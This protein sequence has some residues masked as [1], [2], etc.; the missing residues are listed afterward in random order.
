MDREIA[1]ILHRR[2]RNWAYSGQD[3]KCL[4]ALIKAELTSSAEQNHIRVVILFV[5]MKDAV[6]PILRSTGRLK[7]TVPT[8]GCRYFPI[9]C[10]S[11]EEE[12]IRLVE[13]MRLN[14][15]SEENLDR[16]NAYAEY[17]LDLDQLVTGH[18]SQTVLPLVN[19]YA[20]ISAVEGA[21]N[22]LYHQRK[23]STSER[24]QLLER[25]AEVKNMGP[26]IENY[27][28]MLSNTFFV[29]SPRC[30][31]ISLLQTGDS[32]CF[33]ING[34]M[35]HN[36]VEQLLQLIAWD[37]LD[38]AVA[39]KDVAV[40][41]FEGRRK[42]GEELPD[43]LGRVTSNVNVTLYTNDYYNGHDTDWQS[44]VESYFDA[45]IFSTHASMKSCEAISNAFGTMPVVR[46]SYSC[47]RDRRLANN[48]L[49]DRIFNTNRVDHYIEHIPSWEPIFRKEEIKSLPTGTCLVKA[50][51]NGFPATL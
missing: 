36:R 43:F 20:S 38:T 9:E 6:M 30:R 35:G 27:L 7:G 23:I 33:L 21:I 4:D 37:I 42:F 8:A 51:G 40:S 31:R 41:I 34:D 29:K 44:T 14:G 45:W 5:D 15:L 17:L 16:V 19:K 22:D 47:D 50:D 32:I 26:V 46:S 48:R 49:I 25:Y 10:L 11:K 28:A 24:Q 18:L 3:R 1:E 13:M 39:G 2:G 12:L